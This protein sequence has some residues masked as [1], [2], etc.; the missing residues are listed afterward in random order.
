MTIFEGDSKQIR[1]GGMGWCPKCN[2]VAILKMEENFVVYYCMKC[3]K[4]YYPEEV[5]TMPV[6]PTQ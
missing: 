3:D 4:S 5:L 2:G 1:L 6:E